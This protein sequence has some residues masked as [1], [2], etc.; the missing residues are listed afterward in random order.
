M[1]RV[2][3]ESTKQDE[4][5]TN[6]RIVAFLWARTQELKLC[7]PGAF[8]NMIESHKHQVE[9]IDLKWTNGP[10]WVPVFLYLTAF[11][12]LNLNVSP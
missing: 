11:V 2:S 1:V 7:L 4:S 12:F 3:S 5:Q 6:R 9:S 8:G 10:A